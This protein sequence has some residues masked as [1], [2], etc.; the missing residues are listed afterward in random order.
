[1]SRLLRPL[2]T[3]LLSLLAGAL[4]AQHYTIT[5]KMVDSLSRE[6]LFYVTVGLMTQDSTATVVANAYTDASGNFSLSGV[7]AG[8]YVLKANIVGYDM[9]VRPVTVGGEQRRLNIGEMGMKKVSTTLR[10]VSIAA[11]KPVYMMDGEK[12]LYNVSEDPSI[13]SG[14]ATDALQN[15]PGVEVGVE[16]NV[17][18]RGV[19]SVEIWINNKPSNMNG[20]ALKNFLQQMPADN[21]EKIEVITNPS[22]RYSA[23]SDGG[24]INIVT[25]SDIKKNSFLSFGVRGSSSPNVTPWISYVYANKKFSISTYLN[26]SYSITK[27]TDEVQE[28]AFNNE[29]DTSAF[30]HSKGSNRQPSHYTGLYIN[31][32]YTPD[33]ANSITFWAGTYPSWNRSQASES[34]IRKEYLYAQGDYSYNR[35]SQ[36]KSNNVGGYGGLWYEHRFNNKGHKIN[37]SANFSLWRSQSEGTEDRDFVVMD[38]KDKFKRTDRKYQNLSTSLSL[39]YTVPYHKDGEIEVG[40]SGDFGQNRVVYHEDSLAVSDLDGIPPITYHDTVRSY[41]YRGRDGGVAAYVTLQHRFGRFTLKGGLRAEYEM[42]GLHYFTSPANNLTKGYWGLFPSLHLTYRTKSMHNFKLSYT[43]R[44][45]NPS[46]QSLTT[47]ITYS[48]QSFSTGNPDLRSAYTNAVEAGWTKFIR[49]FG[50]VGINAYFRNTKDEFS[51]FSDVVYSPF[52]GTIVSFTKPVNAGKSLNTGAEF[53][54]MY[55]LKAFMNIRFYA[56][57]FYA[58]SQFQFRDEEDPRLVQNVSYSF[59]LNFW[60]KVW[61]VLEI[62]ASANYRSKTKSL[63]TVN[64]P[65]YSIDLGLKANFWKNRISVYVDVH[66]IFNWNKMSYETNNPYYIVTSTSRSSWSSR[67]VRAGITFRFGKMELESR[68]NQGSG[69]QQEG[70]M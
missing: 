27:G 24:V 34:M 42:F 67:S 55:Q 17:S 36:S 32:S 43:R 9:L 63:F 12:T 52:F 60:T 56:N 54:M 69:M 7:S 48:E 15:A 38:E 61:K 23:Q 62:N 4:S 70:E 25:V 50:N 31:G 13:H 47:F 44:V 53:N 26:Y 65:R 58:R 2:L 18:L 19:S 16:G 22:A 8:T 1:M 49:K 66:D 10:E 28:T 20:D 3:L 11:Q 14:T 64:K 29:G 41:D 39:N 33:T 35:E 30:Y 51:S 40:A 21:I 59:R 37:A 46:A 57:V 68:A 45:N 6:K 5:G